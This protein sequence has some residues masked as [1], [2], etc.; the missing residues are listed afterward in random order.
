MGLPWLSSLAPL[1]RGFGLLTLLAATGC[2]EPIPP[3]SETLEGGVQPLL[4]IAM[5]QD[6]AGNWVLPEDQA[7]IQ[8]LLDRTVLYLNPS[9]EEKEVS[10]LLPPEA[11][12]AGFVAL[13]VMSDFSYRVGLRLGSMEVPS[14]EGG[15]T[16][17]EWRELMFALPS[18]LSFQPG[19]RFALRFGPTTAPVLIEAIRFIP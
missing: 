18:P 8:D 4:T 5:A 15:N 11:R 3:M 17:R 2:G 7:S 14:I 10:H 9:D 1:R 19:E 13:R 6:L 12:G 16:R